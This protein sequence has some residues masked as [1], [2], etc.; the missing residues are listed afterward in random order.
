[1]ELTYVQTHVEGVR[2]VRREH[3]GAVDDA[4][5]RSRQRKGDVAKDEPAHLGVCGVGTYEDVQ[6]CR[7]TEYE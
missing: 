3:E 1:M 6:K 5:P 7:E 4:K 2:P